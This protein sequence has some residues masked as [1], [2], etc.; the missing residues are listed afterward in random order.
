M[1]ETRIPLFLF[2]VIFFPIIIFIELALSVLF[3]IMPYYPIEGAI[4]FIGYMTVLGWLLTS[5]ALFIIVGSF[6]LFSSAF[7]YK[8][9]RLKEF[10][11]S[12]KV[13]RII[14]FLTIF[15]IFVQI[16][17]L[18]ISQIYYILYSTSVG[19]VYL[20]IIILSIIPPFFLY[21]LA[22]FGKDENIKYA[23]SRDAPLRIKLTAL[24][25][26]FLTMTI[27][28]FAT[29]WEFIFIGLIL[30]VTG[31]FFFYLY[32]SAAT[33]TPIT[34]IIHFSFSVLMTVL[35]FVFMDETIQ[36]LMNS[37]EPV[38]I[39]QA[40]LLTTFIFIIPGL[41]SIVLAQSF[42]RKWVL[43][44]IKEAR[45]EPEMAIKLEMVD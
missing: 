2:R 17:L 30:L 21:F 32:R 41:I 8:N 31:Y 44:W 15:L 3:L 36:D 18:S 14:G 20:Q 4:V 19:F 16:V 27:Q 38:T 25:M 10:F 5:T 22:N 43:A 34:L 13:M 9:E 28:I 6:L 42:F 40:A 7:N 23:L 12:D 11:G 26:I 24:W 45:P 39:A 35:S 37:G 33:L 29:N 1:S